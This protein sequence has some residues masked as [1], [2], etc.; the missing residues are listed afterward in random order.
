MKNTPPPSLETVASYFASW[1]KNRG[2]KREPIPESLRNIAT[3]LKSRYPVGQIKAALN[4]NS[5]MLKHWANDHCS[6]GSPQF[7]S[8]PPSST[9]SEQVSRSVKLE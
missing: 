6:N 2:S 5:N 9:V 1:R 8:L 4:V 7:L 3:T